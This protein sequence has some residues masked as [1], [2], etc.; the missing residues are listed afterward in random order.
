VS[1]QRVLLGI[2]V[3]LLLIVAWVYLGPSS[4]GG[5]DAAPP[6]GLNRAA[7]V[8]SDTGLATAPPRLPAALPAGNS[9]GG[10]AGAE[11]REAVLTVVPLRLDELG[12]TPPGFTTG[13]DPWRFVEPPPPPPPP[14]HRPS[15][16]ELEAMRKAEEARQ[17]QLAEA[18]RLAAIEAARP[19][20]PPFTWTYL[21]SFGPA[22]QRIAAFTDGQKVWNAREGDRLEGK[23]IVA[24]IGYESVDIRYVDFPNEPQLRVAAKK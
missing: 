11:A 22:N 7:G 21:G 5:E 4:G 15:A 2:L 9:G 14:P 10:A 18:Q 19:K 16:A 3:A 1:R 20:P 23:F 8:D 12:R 17:K 24:K 13:R 6:R